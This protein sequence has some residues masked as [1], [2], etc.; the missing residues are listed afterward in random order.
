MSL[1]TLTS[2]QAASA[3]T[4]APLRAVHLG[5]LGGTW[6]IAR[7]INN[8]GHVVGDSPVEAGESHA[9]LW[10]NG[11]MT[12]LGTLGG[13]TSFASGIDDDGRVV[14]CSEL[15]S[16]EWSPFLWQNGTMTDLNAHG[17]PG[18]CDAAVA[19]GHITISFAPTPGFTELRAVLL[20][21]DVK[22][23]ID[24]RPG[25]V[26]NAVNDHGQVVGADNYTVNEDGYPQSTY[27][28]YLWH[29]GTGRAL[30]TLG[31]M[32]TPSAINNLGQVVGNS[33]TADGDR[34]GFFWHGSSMTALPLPADVSNAGADAINE[35]GQIVGSFSKRGEFYGFAALWPTPTSQPRTLPVPAQV[36]SSQ[37]HDI[38]DQGWIVGTLD[39]HWTTG[40]RTQAVIWR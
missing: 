14:G 21:G 32:S 24:L 15:P 35:H 39:Y 29:N 31:E 6:S 3:S 34:R 13:M 23:V 22:T 8:R 20:S 38:N 4:A 16:G 17:A 19:R 27:R 37:A 40:L 10:K 1:V 30:G 5:T 7:A 33:D 9:F 26:S 12:D 25:L 36:N 2:P 18:Y 11:K 28:A